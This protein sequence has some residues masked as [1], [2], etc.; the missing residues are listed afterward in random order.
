VNSAACPAL[1]SILQRIAEIVT[2]SGKSGV[3]QVKN[4]TQAAVMPY[5]PLLAD[6]QCATGDSN[7]FQFIIR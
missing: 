4:A 6:A 3:V 1:A 2:V 5:N 7:S